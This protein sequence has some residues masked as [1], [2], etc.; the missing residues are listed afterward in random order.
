MRYTPRTMR[1]TLN[2]WQWLMS[3]SA[4]ALRNAVASCDPSDVAAV[5]K[6]RQAWDADRVALALDWAL[7]RR[8]A[9][10][11]WPD[12][13]DRIVADP[14]G[15]EQAS[16]HAVAAWKA[17]RFA[18]VQGPV[19][20]LCCGIGGDAM[21]IH[22]VAPCG[23]VAVDVHS[24][25]AW[26]ASRN[27]SCPAVTADVSQLNLRGATYHLDPARRDE[28]GKRSH[29]LAD[30]QPG[31]AF[32]RRLFEQC[33]DGAV[34]LGPG[35]D[36]TELALPA[37]LP[38]EW[39]WISEHGTP[40]QAVLWTGRFAQGPRRATGLPACH[41]LAG[42][43][44]PLQ[45]GLPGRYLF[46]VDPVVE[47]SGLLGNLAATHGLHTI[48]FRTGMLTGDE[49]VSSPWL[50][51]F[52]ALAWLPWRPR[53]MQQWLRDHDGGIVEIKSRGG[54]VNTDAMQKQ[55]RGNGDTGYVVFAVKMGHEM[56]AA[57]ARRIPFGSR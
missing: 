51:A 49:L 37:E 35:V 47:L 10:V 46:T 29:Q 4:Q 11:K 15:V 16:S 22:P 36:V 6:L 7:A 43:P 23:V 17:R 53:K 13:A 5:T 41:T 20:D 34:K 24:A 32:W 56:R 45:D 39:E 33:P 31:P 26:M 50:T 42:E 18:G 1:G 40:V 44:V 48:H 3:E 38:A 9:K 21:A 57:M 14:A 8:K 12:V 27:A 30:H 2:D 25:R 19:L 28:R 54:S 52:E 55:L